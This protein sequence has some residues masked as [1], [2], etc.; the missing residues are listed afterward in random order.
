M[1]SSISIKFGNPHPVLKYV[2]YRYRPSKTLLYV[3]GRGGGRGY[4]SLLHSRTQ[5]TACTP[6][7][8]HRARLS[9]R[10]EVSFYLLPL[11]LYAHK[12]FPSAHWPRPHN[13]PPPHLGS[14]A[15][16]LLVSQDRRHL[17]IT[18]CLQHTT[19]LNTVA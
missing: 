9:G 17:F 7:G 1:F 14:Y 4:G 15:R 3:G 2:C 10:E 8:G 19:I 6:E 13:S 16:A 18:P 11:T 12:P 5:T